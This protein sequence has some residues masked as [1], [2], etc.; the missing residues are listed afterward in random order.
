[1]CNFENFR[2]ILLANIDYYS[3][4]CLF[5][6]ALL[7]QICFAPLLNIAKF[8]NQTILRKS[9]RW[10]MFSLNLEPYFDENVFCGLLFTKLF[11]MKIICWRYQAQIVFT[12]MAI[13][14]QKLPSLINDRKLKKFGNNNLSWVLQNFEIFS[15]KIFSGLKWFLFLFF[16]FPLGPYPA[17]FF[18]GPQ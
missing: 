13:Y 2:K 11:Q 17:K 8:N 7:G 14:V 5:P 9:S 4:F 6:Q 15:K 12:N 1:M 10:K 18:L 3:H 16:R